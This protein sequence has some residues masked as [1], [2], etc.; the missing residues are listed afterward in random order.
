MTA[1]LQYKL[2][3]LSSQF[4]FFLIEEKKTPVYITSNINDISKLNKYVLPYYRAYTIFI[5]LFIVV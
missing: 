3:N 1:V 4:L 5:L 2:F